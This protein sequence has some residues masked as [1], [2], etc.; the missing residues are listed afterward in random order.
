M[1]GRCS[2][3][4]AVSEFPM[5]STFMVMSS[6]PIGVSAPP[7]SHEANS[8]VRASKI[9]MIPVCFMIL[10][11]HFFKEGYFCRIVWSMVRAEDVVEPDF[12][13]RI[14]DFVSPRVMEMAFAVH[15]T[16]TDGSYIVLLQ[17]RQNIEKRV[18]VVSGEV[19]LA[20]HRPAETL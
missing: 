7:L 19:L 8:D 11:R 14:S 16:P 20:N 18:S 10:F 15:K 4:S 9:D 3:A 6:G 13:F 12:R 5:K 1:R 2:T 17:N